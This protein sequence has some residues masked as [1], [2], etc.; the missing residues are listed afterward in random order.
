MHVEL[1]AMQQIDISP[2]LKKGFKSV[3]G[4]NKGYITAN[5]FS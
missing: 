4:D 5:C 3:K 1:S 2:A